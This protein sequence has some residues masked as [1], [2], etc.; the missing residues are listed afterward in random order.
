MIVWPNDVNYWFWR[1]CLLR[2]SFHISNV[3]LSSFCG[4][5]LS[6]WW[7]WSNHWPGGIGFPDYSSELFTCPSKDDCWIWEY[8]I[9]PK[10][11]KMSQGEIKGVLFGGKSWN[12]IPEIIFLLSTAFSDCTVN[13]NQGKQLDGVAWWL[14]LAL[15]RLV[16]SRLNS[17]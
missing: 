8:W 11:M 15:P 4:L 6:W 2:S 9:L 16:N 7:R 10:D 1:P 17:I 13:M 5:F 12:M 14:L 3:L